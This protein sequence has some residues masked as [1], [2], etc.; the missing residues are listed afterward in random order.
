MVE[1]GLPPAIHGCTILHHGPV[2]RQIK[3]PHKI[4]KKQLENFCKS[5]D[6]RTPKII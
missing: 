4:K 3:S 1:L 6:I 2:A 5:T